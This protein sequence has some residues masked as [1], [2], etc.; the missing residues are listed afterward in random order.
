MGTPAG[1]GIASDQQVPRTFV[2]TWASWLPAL[3]LSSAGTAWTVALLGLAMG[4]VCRSA[5]SVWA[6][7]AQGR[8]VP[9]D[10]RLMLAVDMTDWRRCAE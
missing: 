4:L 9:P 10:G 2:C 1:R 6:W 5:G 7:H 8:P 3:G